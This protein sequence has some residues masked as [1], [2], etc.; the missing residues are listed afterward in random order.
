MDHLGK[1]G[2]TMVAGQTHTSPLSPLPVSDCTSLL[3]QMKEMMAVLRVVMVLM[4]R[5]VVKVVV[6]V[7]G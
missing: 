6:V 2:F 1:G 4:G 7:V 5:V 3:A